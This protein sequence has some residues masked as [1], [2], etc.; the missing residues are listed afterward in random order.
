MF[1]SFTGDGD[2][3]LGS[4]G[5]LGIEGN[6]GDGDFLGGK[7]TISEVSSDTCGSDEAEKGGFCNVF[8]VFSEA[9]DGEDVPDFVT[10]IFVVSVVIEVVIDV[11]NIF[12]DGH[13]VVSEFGNS[14]GDFFRVIKSG[15]N[16]IEPAIR[17]SENRLTFF[18]LRNI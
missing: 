11:F 15:L 1:T 8:V 16:F 9:I 13:E 4:F 10:G 18:E 5:G 7:T 3:V 17:F 6:S 14:N 12:G 2:A